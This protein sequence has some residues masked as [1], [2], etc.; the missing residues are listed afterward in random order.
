MDFADALPDHKRKTVRSM[1]R[2]LREVVAVYSASRVA[3]AGRVFLLP[4]TLGAFACK[5]GDAHRN[6]QS[7]RAIEQAKPPSARGRGEGKF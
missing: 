7:D 5:G 3:R 1:C 4:R 2:R 6:E